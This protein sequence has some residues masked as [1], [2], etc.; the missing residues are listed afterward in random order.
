MPARKKTSK[1][2]K[3]SKVASRKSTSR[4]TSSRKS[5]SG[6]QPVHLV[7]L[8]IVAAVVVAFFLFFQKST[9][10]ISDTNLTNAVNVPKASLEEKDVM[11]AE[12]EVDSE[13]RIEVQLLEIDNSQQSG[14]AIITEVD[15]KAVVS[16]S[17][18]GSNE[19]VQP[20]HIHY[21]SCEYL[22][23]V[24]YPLTTLVDGKSRTTL[25][26]SLQEL[27]WGRPL[28]I[29]VHKSELDIET[30]VACGNL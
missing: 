14:K 23:D 21:G 27:L 16:V 4:S 2:A 29:N 1:T 17:V 15:G 25:D 10:K 20:V 3:V 11:E 12:E 7:M 9:D 30:D 19:L 24:K 28:A 8:G 6:L 13:N 18:Y 5:S 22:S 26:V